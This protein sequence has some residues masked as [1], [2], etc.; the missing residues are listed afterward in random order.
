MK[1]R[2]TR[3]DVPQDIKDDLL[4]PGYGPL[5]FGYRQYNEDYTLVCLY[6]RLDNCTGDMIKWWFGTGLSNL[7]AYKLWHPGHIEFQGDGNKIP[8]E[9]IGTGHYTKEM[10]SGKE[11]TTH[12]TFCDP[13]DIW[14]MDELHQAGYSA[15]ICGETFDASGEVSSVHLH[16]IRDTYFGCEF[17]YR[18]LAYRIDDETARAM[19]LHGE[20]EWTCI[21][22][23]LP[24]WYRREHHAPLKSG[25]W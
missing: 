10:F 11:F 22:T 20:H 9:Y 19:L 25:Q 8:G 6:A 1:E 4:R 5:E 2:L 21:P 7:Q 23:F 14:D 15:A 24:A 16:M 13:S 12:I 3:F 17:R 18:S